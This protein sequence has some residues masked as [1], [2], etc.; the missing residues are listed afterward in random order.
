MTN[1]T[2]IRYALQTSGLTRRST[3]PGSLLRASNVA[4]FGDGFRHANVFTLGPPRG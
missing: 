3:R 1:S 2:R 4:G